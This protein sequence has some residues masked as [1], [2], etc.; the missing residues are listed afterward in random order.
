MNQQEIH[1]K[2]DELL[3]KAEDAQALAYCSTAIGAFSRARNM[4]E[5]VIGVGPTDGNTNR[6]IISGSLSVAGTKNFE[7]PHPAP[8]KRDTHVIRHGAVESPTAGD[9]LYR[10][11]IEAVTD[12]QQVELQLPDYFQYLNTN[13]DVWANGH[14]HFGRAFGEVAGR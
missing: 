13:V 12:G 11:T 2:L 14:R 9:I 8:H 1:K 3:A 6:W 5:G 10:F 7:I 4:Y